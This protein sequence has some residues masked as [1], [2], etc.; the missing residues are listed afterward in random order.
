M[1]PLASLKTLRSFHKRLFL[2]GGALSL[3]AGQVGA[4]LPFAIRMAAASTPGRF[5]R[6]KAA[7]SDALAQSLPAWRDLL[8]LADAE[9]LL[10]EDGHYV[11]WES[12]ASAVAGRASWIA[13]GTGTARMRDAAEDEK[14]AL[15]RLM[16]QPV[17]SAVRFEGTGQITDLAALADKLAAAFEE[18]GGKRVRASALRLR[19]DG[20]DAIVELDDGQSVH[21]EALV[22]A[23]GVASGQLLRGVGHR[24]PIIAERGYHIQVPGAEWP[25]D[26]PPVVFEDRSMIVTRFR[27]GL[28]AASFVEFGRPDAPPDPRKWERLERHVRELGLPFTGPIERWMG[29]RPTLPDYLP[30]IGRSTCAD[31]LF[32]A[33]GHQHLG[34]TLAAFTSQIMS[35][36][37][38]NEKPA[39]DVSPFSLERFGAG[40]RG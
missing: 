10:R 29:A 19:M 17:A 22:V 6:G 1:E 14:A 38:G 13:A 40:R 34:L 24:A 11:V 20:G 12:P 15:A 31:N 37:V 8:K 3:P 27:S 5:D 26:M 4:W 36:L 9:G 25:E 23:A 28:R 35:A 7:L 30:A 39:M 18:R 21:A 32:Y 33:F 16:Q 2:R